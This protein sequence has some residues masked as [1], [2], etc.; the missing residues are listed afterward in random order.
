[1]GQKVSAGSIL[2]LGG[3]TGRSFGS[4]LH[5][6]IRYLGQALD[7]EDFIDYSKGELKANSFT[8]RKV[9]VENK[10]DLRALHSR[11]RRDVGLARGDRKSMK[12][13]KLGKGGIYTI[14]SGDNLG[15]IAARYHTTVKALCKKNGLSTTSMLKLG[16]RIKI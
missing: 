10:Y 2:G 3:N 1:V 4:H 13:V 16:Q 8:L 6:E 14:R 5:F 15:K 11:H 9:D 12:P 7:T